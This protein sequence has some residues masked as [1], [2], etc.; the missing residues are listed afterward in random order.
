MH[1]ARTALI[2]FIYVPLTFMV[3]FPHCVLA[4]PGNVRLT[5]GRHA[6][7]YPAAGCVHGR[8]E[9]CFFFGVAPRTSV[10]IIFWAWTHWAWNIDCIRAF[11]PVCLCMHAAY[12]ACVERAAGPPRTWMRSANCNMCNAANC[13]THAVATPTHWPSCIGVDACIWP[14]SVEDSVHC[15]HDGSAD[16][17]IQT[18]PADT[19][20]C[21]WLG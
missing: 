10:S 16:P 7:T 19:S 17:D 15:M 4:G 12:V 13:A 8:S 18:P 11:C 9:R 2:A 21:C 20:V 14:T 5:Q 3:C 1:A 6:Q